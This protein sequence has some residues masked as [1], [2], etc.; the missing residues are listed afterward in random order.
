MNNRTFSKLLILLLALASPG[1]K[2]FGFQ[3]IPAH[4]TIAELE[5]QKKVDQ[6]LLLMQKRLALMHEVARTKWN[7]QLPI[8]DL[9]REE[10][11]LAQL[12][13]EAAN[14][15]LEEAWVRQ[16]FQ[17]QFE[18]AKVLQKNDFA[19][20]SEEK[21]QKFDAVLDLKQ[22][23]RPLLDQLTKELLQSLPGIYPLAREGKLASFVLNEPLSRRNVDAMDEAVWQMA[24]RPL[25]ERNG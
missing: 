20:W 6:V 15:G 13:K 11:L 19:A 23:I 18:A 8:E 3:A 12:A 4:Q 5:T 22:T 16:F 1:L 24:I 9:A 2:A 25:R 7:Q 17:A 10:Q 14:I 21:V